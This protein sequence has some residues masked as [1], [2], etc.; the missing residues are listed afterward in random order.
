MDNLKRRIISLPC[1][2]GIKGRKMRK[3]EKAKLKT[4]KTKLYTSKFVHMRD[5]CNG[6]QS[7]IAWYYHVQIKRHYKRSHA[8]ILV[9]NNNV[10]GQGMLFPLF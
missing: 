5:A 4:N 10:Q 7:A 2:R 3:T 6:K 9:R 8:E 1:R